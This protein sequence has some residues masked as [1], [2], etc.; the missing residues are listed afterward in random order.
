[1]TQIIILTYYS[2]CSPTFSQLSFPLPIS[3]SRSLCP[4]PRMFVLKI[5]DLTGLDAAPVEWGE[6]CKNILNAAIRVSSASGN[7]VC[8]RRARLLKALC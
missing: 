8:L 6:G 5:R 7:K 4:F 3:S 1:M 2:L